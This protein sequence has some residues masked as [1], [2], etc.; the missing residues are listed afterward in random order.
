[1]ENTTNGTRVTSVAKDH[2]H[3]RGEHVPVNSKDDTSSGSPPLTWRTPEGQWYRNPLAGIT[4]TYVENTRS[5][6]PVST[7]S[8]D[9]LHL[10]G[11]HN[12]LG[13]WLVLSWG[14]PPLTWRTPPQIFL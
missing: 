7:L 3:L 8:R 10:R 13:L 12:V 4:S 1:M 9:H 14:S 5:N 6:V 11:E 2:L